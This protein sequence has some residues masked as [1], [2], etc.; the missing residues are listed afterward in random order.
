M[1]EKTLNIGTAKVNNAYEWQKVR[2]NN[3][4]QPTTTAAAAVKPK[5]QQQQVQKQKNATKAAPA[6]TTAATTTATVPPLAGNSVTV[7]QGPKIKFVGNAARRQ[8]LAHQIKRAHRHLLTSG[9]QDKQPQQKRKQFIY[10]LMGISN[11]QNLHAHTSCKCASSQ[12]WT[13]RM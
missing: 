5:P 3:K 9:G 11:C 1:Y 6:T 12:P 13:V 4:P 7:K 10:S 2:Y 8:S